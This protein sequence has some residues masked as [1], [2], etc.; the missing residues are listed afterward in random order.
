MSLT[1][2]AGLLGCGLVAF[3]KDA[4][5]QIVFDLVAVL[6]QLPFTTRTQRPPDH[7][8]HAVPAPP[9]GERREDGTPFR[10]NAR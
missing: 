10:P 4:A 5:V 7:W 1:H 8:H 2:V 9:R 3:L 6:V